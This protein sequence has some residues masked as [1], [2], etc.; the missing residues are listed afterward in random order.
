MVHFK[1]GSK[2][3]ASDAKFD[4]HAPDPGVTYSAGD[5]EDLPLLTRHYFAE[6]GPSFDLVVA[7]GNN[8][9]IGESGSTGYIYY[10]GSGKV[11]TYLHITAHNVTAR[12]D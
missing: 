4:D 11:V 1:S 8:A 3:L 10:D 6:M 9:G 7:D 5:G 2:T 12:V